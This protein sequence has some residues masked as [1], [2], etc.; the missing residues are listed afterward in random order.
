MWLEQREKGIPELLATLPSLYVSARSVYCPWEEKGRVMRSLISQ[1]EG[2]SPV[3]EGLR[4]Q[5]EGGG[6]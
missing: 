3:P 6:P 4:V 5:R 2:L 1:E